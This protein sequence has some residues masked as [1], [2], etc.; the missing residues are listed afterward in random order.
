MIDETRVDEIFLDIV[1]L[2]EAERLAALDEVC[3]DGET[4]HRIEQ[5]LG[6]DSRVPS[7]FLAGGERAQPALQQGGSIG[8]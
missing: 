8:P 3:P 1:E 2:P 4:R 7:E 6:W 5:L